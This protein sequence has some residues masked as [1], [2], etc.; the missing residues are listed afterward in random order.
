M[1]VK[2]VKSLCSSLIY[3][4]QSRYWHTLQSL[5]LHFKGLRKTMD[6]TLQSSMY[7]GPS[8][9]IFFYVDWSPFLM[10]LKQ[11]SPPSTREG[12]L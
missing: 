5:F 7:F 10:A 8:A 9:K 1:S 3:V 11:C 2:Q 4:Q 6:K 12:P